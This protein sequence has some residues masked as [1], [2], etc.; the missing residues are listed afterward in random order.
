MAL[1]NY[2]KN[3]TADITTTTSTMYTAP[4]EPAAYT[5]IVLMAQVVNVTSS[6]ATV[7]VTYSKPG[8]DTEIVKDFAVPG[9][10][11]VSVVT[12]KLVIETGCSIKVVGSANNTL[13]ITVSVLETANE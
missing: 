2:F 1:F 9:N 10:D 8:G 12:G 11:A 3:A 6:A 4:T 13:K 7:T 5:A